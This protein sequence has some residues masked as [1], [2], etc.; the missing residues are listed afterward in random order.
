MNM[1]Q[2]RNDGPRDKPPEPKL[3]LIFSFWLSL[4]SGGGSRK[5]RRRKEAKKEKKD[6]QNGRVTLFSTFP[7]TPNFPHTHTHTLI[8]SSLSSPL[9]LYHDPRLPNL[10]VQPVYLA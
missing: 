8:N 4:K 10:F 1:S 7:K 9:L 6:D 2:S 5:K 3:F